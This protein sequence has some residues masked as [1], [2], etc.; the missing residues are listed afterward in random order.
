MKKSEAVTKLAIYIARQ[1]VSSGNHNIDLSWLSISD[2][3]D[4]ITQELGMLPP[5]SKL[6][7]LN[8]FDNS[9]EPEDNE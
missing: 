5:T 7:K 3:I 9:W 1:A 4:H 6:S 8:T 2:L